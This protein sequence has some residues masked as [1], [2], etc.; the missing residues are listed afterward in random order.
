MIHLALARRE[1][2]RPYHS[3]WWIEMD[4]G[5]QVTFKSRLSMYDSNR[6]SS[7]NTSRR[8]PC[9]ENGEENISESWSS[10]S[11]R[12]SQGLERKIPVP[13]LSQRPDSGKW[14]KDITNK[15]APRN[16]RIAFDEIKNTVTCQ[17][18]NIGTYRQRSFCL[19]GNL[20]VRKLSLL[21]IVLSHQVETR[22]FVPREMSGFL[23]HESFMCELRVHC[24]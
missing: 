22:R 17:R 23:R 12:K 3:A 19:N 21:V 16:G 18:S 7:A 2:G 14:H 15:I 9:E 6:S 4:S 5:V 10:L 8:R 20:A 1:A 24:W 11:N 13:R